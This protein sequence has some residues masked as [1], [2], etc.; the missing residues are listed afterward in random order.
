MS[1]AL[2]NLFSFNRATLPPPFDT[3]TNKKISVAS[4]YGDG[5]QATL[6][7][8]VIKALNAVCACMNGSG[9]GAVGMIDHRSVAEYKSSMGPDAYHW[10]SLTAALA[11]FQPQST[12][13]TRRPA[14][15]MY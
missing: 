14:S 2:N 3:V 10:R 9:E 4:K 1:A 5:K 15:C 11:P 13:K 6:C 12:T 7:F 8:T